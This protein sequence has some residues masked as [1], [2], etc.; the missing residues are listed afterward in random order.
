MSSSR[1]VDTRGNTFHLVFY[2]EL[3]FFQPDFFDEVFGIQ[4]GGLREF[5]KFCFVLMV[6]L[7]QTLVFGVCIEYYV[8]RAPLRSCHAFLLKTDGL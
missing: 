4:V 1:A 6:L 2:V 8:P 5:L 3:Q 7:G